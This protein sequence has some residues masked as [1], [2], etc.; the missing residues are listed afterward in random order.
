MLP[1][2]LKFSR[3]SLSSAS[4][5]IL[6]QNCVQFN[7][8]YEDYTFEDCFLDVKTEIRVPSNAL[9]QIFC[10]E[11]CDGGSGVAIKYRIKS[12]V[13]GFCKLT[14]D[15]LQLHEFRL[16]RFNALSLTLSSIDFELNFFMA[17]L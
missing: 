11:I 6:R 2:S 1:P 16:A 7:F 12:L 15:L 13:G 9:V 3:I 8:L 17:T 5:A 4:K 10:E 14:D